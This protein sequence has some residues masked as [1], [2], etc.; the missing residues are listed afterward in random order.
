MIYFFIYKLGIFVN[1]EKKNVR[2][3]DE[4]LVWILFSIEILE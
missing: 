3:N 1:F 4:N 2:E